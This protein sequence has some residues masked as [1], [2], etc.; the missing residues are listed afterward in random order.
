MFKTNNSE[1]HCLI[2]VSIK[3]Y[4][5][6]C[7]YKIKDRE[8]AFNELQLEN[9][10]LRDRFLSFLN[11]FNIIARRIIRDKIKQCHDDINDF[12]NTASLLE[13]SNE[14]SVLVNLNLYYFIT[15]NNKFAGN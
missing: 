10:V 6:A 14:E 11:P 5:S 13:K 8:M 1:L 3:E 9:G 2:S 15:R 12:S 4:I 7:Q